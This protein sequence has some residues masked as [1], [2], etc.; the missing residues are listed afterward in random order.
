MIV[1]NRQGVG[2]GLGFFRWHPVLDRG[3]TNGK[4]KEKIQ[5]EKIPSTLFD[6]DTRDD[7]PDYQQ[8]Y[9]YG[10]TGTGI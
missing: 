10:W 4:N 5:V 6:D 7:L 9:S 8:L 3:I 1:K 2:N